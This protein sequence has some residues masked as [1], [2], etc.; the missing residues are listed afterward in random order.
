MATLTVTTTD[1]VVNAGDGVL[2]LREAVSQ[3]NAT[4]AADTIV[5]A[6][7]IEG[8]TLVL[9]GGELTASRDLTIDGNQN[10]DETAITISGNRASR[11]LNV[12][13]M[14]TDI[15]LHDLTI[16]AGRTEGDGDEF[17]RG[18]GEDGGAIKFIG[19]NLSVDNLVLSENDGYGLGGA[20]YFKGSAI[21][22][23]NSELATNNSARGGAIFV[24][25]GNILISLSDFVDNDGNYGGGAMESR[26][27]G[28]TFIQGSNFLHNFAFYDG[29]ALDLSGNLTLENSQVCYNRARG[30]YGFGSQGGGIE[31]A[32]AVITGC[33]ISDN[34]ADFGGGIHAFGKLSINNSTIANNYAGYY[35]GGSGGGIRIRG[36]STVIN[37]ST[38]TGNTAGGSPYG[39]GVG[40]G[41]SPGSGT[42]EITNSIVAGNS[43]S[44][45][46]ANSPEIYGT[47]TRSN[48]HNIF[49]SDVAGNVAGD[50]ENVAASRLFAGGLADN[51]GPTPTI[52]LRD[53]ADNP[54]LAG[55]N[56][57]DSPATDQRGVARPQP[58]GTNPDIG[59][60]EL[61]QSIGGGPTVILGNNR[62]EVLLGTAGPDLMRGF[63]GNDTL[64]GFGGADQ[65]FGGAGN[66][67]L[68]G[69]GGL[70]RLQ[71]D[72]GADRFALRL[73]SDAPAGGPAYD[74]I[75]DF[76]RLQHDRIDLGQLD[77]VAGTSGNQ[78]FRFIGDD[79]F[80]RAGQL[81]VEATADGDFLVSGNVDRDLDADFAFVVH[82]GVAKL[83]AADF[84]L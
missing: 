10:N 76:S 57:A 67:V 20:I 50:L 42:L 71:G 48:G 2:S 45:V 12:T 83:V 23:E 30:I 59:A 82:T 6:S 4:A 34:S 33:T 72:A 22:I 8:Q 81:R 28:E 80:S 1:D 32:S 44:G 74:E 60:F 73:L 61:N 40:G 47:I 18:E 11:I 46:G 77:A 41:I 35:F 56:P 36:D 65:L 70:D 26:S 69:K 19:R 39:G 3:A 58:A 66:D 7:A 63:G 54:A 51:G 27:S 68:Y 49:G 53:A 55:A 75:L 5:F 21:K 24:S 31:C 78:A 62:G 38:I 17:N 9:T 29:G 25:T 84:L 13:G 52:A 43:V 37:N 79:P 64:R 15:S 16:T 14:E